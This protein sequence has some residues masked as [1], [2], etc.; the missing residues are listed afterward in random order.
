MR[1][2]ISSASQLY[3]SVRSRAVSAPAS[4]NGK[5]QAHGRTS[6]PY[7]EAF[8]LMAMNLS[9][10]LDGAT[11]RG[12]VV[13]SANRSDGSGS[14]ATN[15]AIAMA[16]RGP[17]LLI[18]SS[19]PDDGEHSTF[20]SWSRNGDMNPLPEHMRHMA[21]ATEHKRLW[22]FTLEALSLSTFPSNVGSLIDDVTAAGFTTIVDAAPATVSAEAF[23]LALEVGQVMY[24]VRQVGNLEV[25]RRIREQLTR[26][27]VRVLGL[28]A[29]EG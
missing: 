1:I 25:H 7:A 15:L 4:E 2:S 29:N 13:M 6:G 3:Q 17:V 12:V 19:A 28:V 5:V 26:L 9:L 16:Q 23:E 22:L 27:G 10:M 11:R 20:M 21:A 14:V 18:A 24:V 8:K